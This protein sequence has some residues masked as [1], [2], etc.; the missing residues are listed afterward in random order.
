[1]PMRGVKSGCNTQ[2]YRN[3]KHV[4]FANMKGQA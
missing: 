1:M 4:G 3:R 2:T